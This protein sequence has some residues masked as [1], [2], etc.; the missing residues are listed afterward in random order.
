MSDHSFSKEIFLNIQFK[1]PLV[2]FEAISSRPI[3]SYLAEETN[4]GL[5]A[6]SFQVV[7][8]SSKV[9]PQPPLLQ[10]KQPK[11]PQLL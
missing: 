9:P 2:Q 1:L 10:T 8:E 6:T 5:T 4:T 7:V 3:T 11:L